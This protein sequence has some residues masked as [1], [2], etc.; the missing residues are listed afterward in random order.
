MVG[1]SEGKIWIEGKNRMGVEVGGVKDEKRGREIVWSE[2][3]LWLRDRND[4][5][6]VKGGEL[7]ENSGKQRFSE[8]N[9]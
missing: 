9:E 8:T 2:G 5:E 7:V 1:V 4:K 6:V 3:E